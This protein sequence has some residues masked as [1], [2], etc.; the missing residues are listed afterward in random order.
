[1]TIRTTIISTLGSVWE[2]FVE[3]SP[4]PDWTDETVLLDTGM[5]SLA[6]AVVVTELEDALGFDPFTESAE[7]VYPETFGQFVSFYQEFSDAR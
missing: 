7:P 3:D 5:D 4:L 1:M 6:F 2:D